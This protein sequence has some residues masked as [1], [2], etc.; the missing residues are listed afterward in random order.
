[1]LTYDI[2]KLDELDEYCFYS[3][4]TKKVFNAIKKTKSTEF[5]I[6]SVES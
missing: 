3:E 4:D 5:T 6:L 2:S 1:M